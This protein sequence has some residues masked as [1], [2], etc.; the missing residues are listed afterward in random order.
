MKLAVASM[1]M[2]IWSSLHA[3]FDVIQHPSETDWTI[4]LQD[5]RYIYSLKKQV[6]SNGMRIHPVRFGWSNPEHIVF[7]RDY[8]GATPSY[9]RSVV[10]QRVNAGMSVEHLVAWDTND[11]LDKVSRMDGAIGYGSGFL[12]I[13]HEDSIRVVRI[14]GR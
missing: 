8:L 14:I 1:L 5:L 11:M 9:F 10:E 6:W 2:L 3:D 12:M 13:D 4:T 7:V